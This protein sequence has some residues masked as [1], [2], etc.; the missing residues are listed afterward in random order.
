MRHFLNIY[1][2]AN[3]LKYFRCHFYRIIKCSSSDHRPWGLVC[4]AQYQVTSTLISYSDA[5]LIKLLIIVL[6]LGFLKLEILCL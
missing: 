5:I 3:G 4:H 2:K 1:A 6:G